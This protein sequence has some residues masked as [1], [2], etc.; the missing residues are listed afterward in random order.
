MT[1]GHDYKISFEYGGYSAVGIEQEFGFISLK[2][3]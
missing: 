1:L 3:I 2:Q